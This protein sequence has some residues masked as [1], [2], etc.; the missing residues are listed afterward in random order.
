MR[1]NKQLTRAEFQ[2]MSIL[3]NLPTDEGHTSEILARYDEP[4]PAYTTLA[5]FLKILSKKGYVKEVKK[6][7]RLFFTPIVTK[8]EYAE[9][10]LTPAKDIFFD[11]K[12]EKLCA[13]FLNKESLTQEQADNI[14]A[15]VRQRVNA[16]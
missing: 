5:T 16:Q 8:E 1:N 15:L 3:W 2:V 4:K 7:S 13:F 6:G 12:I 9:I 11:K 10:F 14:I